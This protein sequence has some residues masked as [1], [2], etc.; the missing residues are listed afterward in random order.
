MN[1]QTNI[2]AGDGDDVFRAGVVGA[3]E[4]AALFDASPW[5]TH[6]ELW[7]RK[8]G[9]I[10]TPDFGGNERIEAGIRLE[11]AIIEWA[12]DKWGYQR[13]ETPK[14]YDNGRGLGG[15]PD[16]LVICPQRGNGLLEVK[17]ADWLVAKNWGDEP[18]LQYQLQAM[19]YMGLSGSSWGDIV[20]LVG[21]NELRR[22][23]I[24][25]RPKL[26]AEIERRVEAFW[27]SI[28]DGK[29]PKPDYTRDGATIA[30]LN[31]PGG[32]DLIDLQGDNLAAIAAA[33]YLASDEISK[34]AAK[35]R[36]AAKAELMDKLGEA[37][38]AKLDGFIVKAPTINAIPDTVITPEMVG[39][40]LKGRKAYRRF[41]IKEI[42]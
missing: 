23:Q 34:E 17:T 37:G 6:F 13:R 8:N 10:A 28:R 30:E 36:E 41:S 39:E 26:F 27:Q 12:C 7:H 15:H 2:M 25:F 24:E 40:V 18:P 3:S 11:P 35:R 9:T 42:N 16:Q 4:V 31:T 21:G 29:A 22:F 38:V 32:D 19:A 1:V 20:I 33:E 14:R 5:L